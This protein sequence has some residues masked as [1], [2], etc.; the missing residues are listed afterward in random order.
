M[1][2]LPRPRPALS[3]LI[4]LCLVA[5]L[6]LPATTAGR[7]PTTRPAPDTPVTLHVLHLPGILGPARID[8]EF[9]A[10]LQAGLSEQGVNVTTEIIDWV[11]DRK[12]LDAL[13]QRAEN[14][15]QADQL[16]EHIRQLREQS[17]DTWFILTAHSGGVGVATWTAERLA[18]GDVTPPPLA[19]V[20]YLAGALSPG[21][22]L[23]G[24]AAAIEHGTLNFVSKHDSI[25]LGFGTREQGTVDGVHTNSAGMVGLLQPTAADPLAYD[26]IWE[27]PYDRTFSTL[28]HYGNHIGMM[29]TRFAREVVAPLMLHQLDLLPDEERKAL[30]TTRPVAEAS[31]EK[32]RNDM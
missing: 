22:D 6:L 1:N 13:Q 20:V 2:C 15:R 8:R 27:V 30:P 25:I 5:L 29:Q 3:G 7:E 18:Q 11:D 12:P 14:E 32:G 16:A 28:G 10:G 9:L 19:Q 23:T 21:Y 17:P 26:R 31:A 4:V 24:G